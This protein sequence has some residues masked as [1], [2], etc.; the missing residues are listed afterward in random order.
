MSFTDGKPRVATVEDIN[1]CWGAKPKGELFRCAFC[2]YKFK[3]GDYWRWQYT[4][5]I[6]GAW[7]N[8]MVCKDCD[9]EPKK[10]CEKWKAM[11]QEA[12]EK[13]WWFVEHR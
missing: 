6:K 9:D 11:H 1:A 10:V 8:P 5:N 2:G 4:N 3:V 13:Y 7:G 12:R